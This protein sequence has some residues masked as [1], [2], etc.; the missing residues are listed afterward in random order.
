MIIRCMLLLCIAAA[1]ATAQSTPIAWAPAPGT[2][3]RGYVARPDS[4]TTTINGWVI[5]YDGNVAALSPCEE[6]DISTRVPIDSVFGLEAAR[7]GRNFLTHVG[8]SVAAGAL[9]GVTVGAAAGAGTNCNGADGPCGAGLT[10]PVGFVLGAG[11]GLVVG[12]VTGAV[13]EQEAW[14]AVRRP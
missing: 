11:V 3:I 7:P 6:C 9:V 5:R 8:K 10:L 4:T 1:T 12:V 2:H 13:P 14:M